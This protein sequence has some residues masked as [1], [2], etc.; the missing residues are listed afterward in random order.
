MIRKLQVAIDWLVRGKDGRVYI[1]QFPNLPIIGWF[2]SMV[3][4]QVTMADIKTGFSSISFAFLSI[5][6]YLEIT[7]G[8]SRF[9]RILGGVVAVVLAYELLG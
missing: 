3:I 7:Q 2:V 8:S 4:A 1:F 6:C 9:R 5:W